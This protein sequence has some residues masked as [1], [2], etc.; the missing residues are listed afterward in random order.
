MWFE[1]RKSKSSMIGSIIW[2]GLILVVYIVWVVKGPAIMA[3]LFGQEFVDIIMQ[4]LIRIN[5]FFVPVSFLTIE[6]LTIIFL[7]F[8]ILDSIFD[9][10][11]NSVINLGLVII[12]MFVGFA[13]FNFIG[14]PFG[15]LTLTVDPSAVD[16][17]G[18]MGFITG[19]DGEISISLLIIFLPM[20]ATY[21]AYFVKDLLIHLNDQKI[22]KDGCMNIVWGGFKDNYGELDKIGV[23][24]ITST[25]AIEKEEP[26]IMKPIIAEAKLTESEMISQQK[27]V[28][29]SSRKR[30]LLQ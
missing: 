30:R 22:A 29:V 28:T 8:K 11:G 14:F 23:A 7:I 21:S 5:L 25:T 13:N 4:N 16:A 2:W 20:L 24:Q 26:K 3:F 19:I 15:V 9:G 1:G 17:F 27:P 6:I 10:F 18:D 12:L